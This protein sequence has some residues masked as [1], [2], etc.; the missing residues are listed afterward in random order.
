MKIYDQIDLIDE[1]LDG[2]RTELGQDFLAYKN[3]C[4]RVFNYCMYFFENP[5]QSIKTIAI[6]A[7]F[8]DLGIWSDKTYDYLEPSK[9]LVREYLHRINS[10]ILID[11][12]A[13]MIEYHHKL[14]PF[15]H[16][17][18]WHVESFRKADWIDVSLGLFKFG[19]PAS[20]VDEVRTRFP[21]AGF[22][23]RLVQLTLHRM[24]S[25][26]FSPLPM[27]RL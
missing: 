15:K 17:P 10:A 20:F 6:T 3:H 25:H 22:H 4:Y 14:T 16:H 18:E 8:H 13:D 24:K 11:E 9:R 2:W 7:A 23:Q 5:A 26:P 19:L 1:I 12:I 21:N 27:M